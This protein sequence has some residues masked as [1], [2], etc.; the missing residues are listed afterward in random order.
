MTEAQ[1]TGLVGQ[2]T[3]ICNCDPSVAVRYLQACN[4][5][6][7]K[8][9]NLLIAGYNIDNVSSNNTQ[10][11][12]VQNNVPIIK[13]FNNE[14]FT[15]FQEEAK[16]LRK[17]CFVYVKHDKY[18]STKNS[19]QFEEFDLPQLKKFFLYDFMESRFH[20]LELDPDD[21]CTKWF[22]DY[23]NIPHVPCIAIIH[24][25]TGA[26]L[27]KYNGVMTPQKITEFLNDFL[28]KNVDFGKPFN[29]EFHC[30]DPLLNEDEISTPPPN[31]EEND[32]NDNKN[33]LVSIVLET[34]NRKRTTISVKESDTIK[35][36]YEK[37]SSLLH[38]PISSISLQTYS[39]DDLREMNATIKNM[40]QQIMPTPIH[41]P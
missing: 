23:Y 14:K 8:A 35:L 10:N 11:N 24:P 5:D 18:Q 1:R 16:K 17:W 37:V 31:V 12:D 32:D 40:K 19:Q 33:E 9:V 26:C 7:L 34:I 22:K 3:Q 27:S 38:I 15:H 28:S 6:L 20:G 13:S 41:M 30:V 2:L 36:L 21:V 39:N 4:W 29:F 25:D